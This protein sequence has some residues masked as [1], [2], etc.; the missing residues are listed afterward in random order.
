MLR[1]IG[2]EKSAKSLASIYYNKPFQRITKIRVYVKAS[3]FT[4]Y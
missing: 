1:A 3:K 2:T 4:I